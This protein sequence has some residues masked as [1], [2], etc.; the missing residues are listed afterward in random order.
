MTFQVCDKVFYDLKLDTTF[1]HFDVAYNIFLCLFFFFFFSLWKFPRVP[2]CIKGFASTN[3]G[4][5]KKGKKFFFSP[6]N[7]NVIEVN[8][9]SFKIKHLAV[10]TC[11]N[12][13]KGKP[14]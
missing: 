8:Y 13:S 4:S 3:C 6:G 2:N 5:K 7:E 9:L 11:D 10:S 12:Y 14:S 1:V